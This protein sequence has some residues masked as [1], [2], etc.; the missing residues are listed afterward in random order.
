MR[1]Y[2]IINPVTGDNIIR[3]FSPQQLSEVV[4]DGY[5]IIIPMN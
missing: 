4:R 1:K 2:L 3:A 5:T